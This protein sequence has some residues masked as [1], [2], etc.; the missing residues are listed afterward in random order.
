MKQNRH[1]VLSL[2]KDNRTAIRHYGV[3]S[4]ALFGSCVRGEQTDASDLDFVVEFEKKTFDACMGLKG[5]LENLFQCPVDLVIKE[6]IKPRL[7]Q[8]IL[9][10]AIN[11]EGL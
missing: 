5:F 1:H 4:L 3:K 11:A 2:I 7:R 8:V 6:A 9:G 10:E